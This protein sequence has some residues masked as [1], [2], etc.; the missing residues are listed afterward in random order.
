[1]ASKGLKRLVRLNAHKVRVDKVY[2]WTRGSHEGKCNRWVELTNSTCIREGNARRWGWCT[3]KREQSIGRAR[4]PIWCKSESE[5]TESR[6]ADTYACTRLSF[7]GNINIS[8]EKRERERDISFAPHP[9]FKSIT[10]AFTMPATLVVGF[11]P[12][13]SVFKCKIGRDLQILFV[14]AYRMLWND[15]ERTTHPFW[16]ALLC[17]SRSIYWLGS[18]ASRIL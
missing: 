8:L 3:I 13:R 11:S 10:I 9:E 15:V 18:L 2:N 1:M 4:Y 5:S 16:K 7:F 6:K 12:R 14:R 17:L